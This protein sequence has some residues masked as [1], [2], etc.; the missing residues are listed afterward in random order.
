MYDVGTYPAQYSQLG[1]QAG[2]GQHMLRFCDLHVQQLRK[3]CVKITRSTT[4]N[5]RVST[6]CSLLISVSCI[7]PVIKVIVLP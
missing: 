4:D 1:M 3:T 2:S 5:G 7:I 6:Q